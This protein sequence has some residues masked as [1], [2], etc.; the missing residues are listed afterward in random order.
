MSG[1]HHFGFVKNRFDGIGAN[2]KN[3]FWRRN[4]FNIRMWIME[5]ITDVLNARRTY[6][7]IRWGTDWVGQL[8][9]RLLGPG[10]CSQWH[11]QGRTLKV[12]VFCVWRPFVIEVRVGKMRYSW[13]RTG[14][15]VF[16]RRFLMVG[17]VCQGFWFVRASGFFRLLLIH[18]LFC[19]SGV[20]RSGNTSAC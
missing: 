7:H 16:V 2:P 18:S 11:N 8:R 14:F 4:L 10:W 17:D 12:T 20:G 19:Q 13:G 9:V 15:I 3:G 5:K 1:T 6:L